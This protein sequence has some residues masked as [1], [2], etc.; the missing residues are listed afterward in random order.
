MTLSRYTIRTL[1]AGAGFALLIGTASAQQ[2]PLP[3]K[4]RSATSKV[5]EYRDIPRGGIPAEE[6]KEAQ[7]NFAKFAR[8]YA[9]VVAHPS[10]YKTPQ[11]FKLAP[12]GTVPLA[13][14]GPNGI[15]QDLNRFTLEA[16]PNSTRVGPGQ[17]VYIRE[18]GAAFDA[19]LKEL[20]EKHPQAIVRVN[21]ARLLAVVCKSGSPA[22][23]PTL[24]G[25]LS[26]ANTRTEI[27]YYLLQAAGN[28]LSAYDPDWLKTRNHVAQTENPKMVGALIKV[29]NDAVTDPTLIVS[30]L[31]PK[32]EGAT[33]DQ[34]AVVGMVRRQAIKAL[35]QVRYVTVT[36]PDGNPLYP[37][38]TLCRV[39]LS[40]PK[41]VPEPGPAD[42]AEAVIGICNMAPVEPR[43][44]RIKPL[45]YN[46]DAALE[47]INAGLIT[48][49]SPRARDAFDIQL[50]W[51]SYA[52]RIAEALRN[53]RM[54]LDPDFEVTR[55][56]TYDPSRV[57]KSVEEFYK[58]VVPKVL[59]PMDR[60]D[61]AGKPDV[62]SAVRIE[63]LRSRLTT[64]RANPKRPL[65]LIPDVPATSIDL[66]PPKK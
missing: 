66:G 4:D 41:L 10:V 5:L 30:G 28:L 52:L 64:V 55:P 51:R 19:A 34:L 35:A 58:D 24:T 42:A 63:D 46:A 9:E 45:K 54:L 43:G 2:Q 8:Y 59:A 11:E 31:R 3:E 60:V 29:V 12:P 61:A 65:V 36:G 56:N 62:G 57:P 26:N 44:D 27:K 20:I 22:H 7:A 15:I 40:D 14:D 25:L 49:A 37:V 32:L 6:L 17:A 16:V 33:P 39:A 38:Q 47:A 13:L 48:F 53:W 50:P 23:Y 21:A 18:F 1:F